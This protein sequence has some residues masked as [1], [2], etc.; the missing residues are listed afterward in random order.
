MDTENR[1]DDLDKRVRTLEQ[2]NSK[3]LSTME[4][5]SSTLDNFTKSLDKRE[6]NDS[7]RFEK[8]EDS[9]SS[10]SKFAYI[11]IGGLLLL[12]FLMSSNILSLGGGKW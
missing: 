3:I 7:K 11:G 9:Q 1:L 6:E 12:Q 4:H 5:M 10:L 8:F 2:D